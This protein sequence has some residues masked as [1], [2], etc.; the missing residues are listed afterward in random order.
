MRVAHH[1]TAQARRLGKRVR[2]APIRGRRTQLPTIAD[3]IALRRRNRSRENAHN[4]NPHPK[5]PRFIQN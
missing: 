5:M 3:P 4:T 1:Q 2:D